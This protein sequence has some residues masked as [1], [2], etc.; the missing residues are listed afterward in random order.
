MFDIDSNPEEVKEIIRNLYFCSRFSEKQ[1]MITGDSECPPPYGYA[2]VTFLVFPENGC[3]D[4]TGKLCDAV[5][6]KYMRIVEAGHIVETAESF[7]KMCYAYINGKL[8][9]ETDRYKLLGVDAPWYRVW[10]EEDAVAEEKRQMEI[11]ERYHQECLNLKNQ[12][13]EEI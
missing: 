2:L 1:F 11:R 12:N 3:I 9:K 10:T 13:N 7:V 4:S 5:A 6:D 8:T